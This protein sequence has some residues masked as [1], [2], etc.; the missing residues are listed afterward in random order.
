MLSLPVSS[1]ETTPSYVHRPKATHRSH[2]ITSSKQ[3]K[4]GIP[5][6][7]IT[8]DFDDGDEPQSFHCS[9]SM[10]L[11]DKGRRQNAKRPS[12]EPSTDTSEPYKRARKA[13]NTVPRST[14]SLPHGSIAYRETPRQVAAAPKRSPTKRVGHPPKVTTTYG[15]S[16]S[17]IRTSSSAVRTSSSKGAPSRKASR[18]E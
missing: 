6:D 13:S 12:G 4:A 15:S 3:G 14:S 11:T 10:L 2:G 17:H 18:S 7:D 9:S 1:H 8:D 5:H 16:H